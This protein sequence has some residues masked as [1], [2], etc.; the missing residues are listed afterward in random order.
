MVATCLEHVVSEFEFGVDVVP[1]RLK[2]V[3]LVVDPMI[4]FDLCK[5]VLALLVRHCFLE[6]MKG[7][8]QARKEIIEPGGHG[9]SGI[10][11]VV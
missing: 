5:R 10:G 8:G 1:L 4:V 7:R 6:G 3:V 11:G 2:A 9:I